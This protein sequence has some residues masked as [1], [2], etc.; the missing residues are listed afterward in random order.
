MPVRIFRNRRPR[1]LAPSRILRP[2][3]RQI[4]GGRWREDLVAD[5]RR[6]IRKGS[7]NLAFAARLLDKATRE[8]VWLLYA[9]RCRCGEIAG[10]PIPPSAPPR[11]DGS[12]PRVQ[13]IRV[14][15]RRALEGEPTADPAFD[16]FGQVAMEARLDE[17]MAADAIEGLSLDASGWRPRSETDLMRYCYHAAGAPAVMTAQAIGAGPD[18]EE[19]LDRAV[20]LGIAFQLV[21]IVRNLSDDDAA[22]GCH[23]PA[24]WLAEADIPPGEHMKPAYRAQLVPL[25][26]RLL[27]MAEQHEATGRL[28]TDVLSYRQRWAVLTASNVYLAIAAKLRRKGAR[29]WD[30]RVRANPLDRLKAGIK[31]VF[32]ALDHPPEPFAHPQWNRGR[33]LLAVRMAGPIPPIPMTPL[34]DEDVVPVGSGRNQG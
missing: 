12:D 1:M 3:Q 10:R 26:G 25:V 24:E 7:R 13:A 22:N 14:L 17:Q 31:A 32:E 30:R 28:C 19:L 23:I 27:D 16:A 4:G 29:A 20:D 34:P 8:R 9:W 33:I 6:A 15:T 21:E 18:D 5:A 2:P 11:R